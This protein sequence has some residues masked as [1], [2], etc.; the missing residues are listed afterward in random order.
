MLGITRFYLA[1]AVVVTHLYGGWGGVLAVYCFYILSGFLITRVLHE[2]YRFSFARFALNRFLRL[3]PMYF[4][5]AG[6][7][8]VMLLIIPDLRTGA[9]LWSGSAWDGMAN[10]F[11]L[12]MAF[13]GPAEFRLVPPTWS[14]GVELANYF[15]LW[16]L[17]ARRSQ[18][19]LIGLALG[20]AAHFLTWWLRMP[21]VYRY[22]PI[23]ASVLPFALGA[24]AYFA[25]TG[26]FCRLKSNS[27]IEHSRR[28]FFAAIAMMFLVFILIARFQFT[29]HVETQVFPW[30]FYG[31]QLAIFIG[32][33]TNERYTLVS[34]DNVS[35]RKIDRVLG[36]LAYPVFLVHILIGRLVGHVLD[37]KAGLTLLL[38]SLPLILM[39]S[40]ALAKMQDRWVEQ[41]RNRVRAAPGHIQTCRM[42]AG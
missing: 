36:D 7:T 24:L 31:V 5:V 40:V 34:K 13:L 9:W 20:L 39:A 19:A 29:S 6:A 17:L 27:D 21:W 32:I 8:A 10:L 22:G 16:V 25:C 11:L 23:Y 33:I 42:P 28:W 14:V 37:L 1:L 38:V 41:F 26:L 2:T 4:L 15:L 30:Y 3:F 35:L 12:P 18:T